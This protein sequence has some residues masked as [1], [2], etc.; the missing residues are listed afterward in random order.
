MLRSLRSRL[1][2]AMIGSITVLLILF[3]GRGE[4]PNRDR[5]HGLSADYGTSQPRV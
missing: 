2:A 5:Q 4:H 1:L 3:G